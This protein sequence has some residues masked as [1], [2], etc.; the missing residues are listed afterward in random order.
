MLAE[1]HV[2][3]VRMRVLCMVVLVLQAGR[4]GI[5]QR[6]SNVGTMSFVAHPPVRMLLAQ[7]LPCHIVTDQLPPS[8]A[9]LTATRKRG[10]IVD[11]SEYAQAKFVR[12]DRE[13]IPLQSWTDKVGHKCQKFAIAHV[14][15]L[16]QHTLALITFHLRE[17]RAHVSV[18]E[19]ITL[20]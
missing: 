11:E 12:Q 19:S 20:G 9:D 7:T 5:L 6:G 10:R 15:E 3:T 4:Q 18:S 14:Q 13:W 1:S 17:G 16:R 2:H 8:L